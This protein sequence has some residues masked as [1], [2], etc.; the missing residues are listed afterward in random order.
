LVQLPANYLTKGRFIDSHCHLDF[1]VFDDDR[2]LILETCKALNFTAIL[3]PGVCRKDWQHLIE[4]CQKNDLLVP[5]IGLHPCFINAH[6]TGDLD[7]LE[8][9]CQSEPIVALGEM[10]LDYFILKNKADDHNSAK[11]TQIFY[12]SQQLKI[13]T[14]YQLPV[15]IHARKSHEQVIQQLKNNRSLCGIIHA[16]SGSYEQ[17]KE[18]LKLGF[19]LGFGGAFTYPNATKL[20]SLIKRLP[21]DAW[22]LE[23]DAP[24]M[25]PKKYHGQRNSPQYL[26]EIMQ[27]FLDL[28]AS[29]SENEN[30]IAQ[31]YA[32]T[33][34]VLPRLKNNFSANIQ[35]KEK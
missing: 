29:P 35:G 9:L 17:A 10:G 23:T 2:T 5:A 22:V 25:S 24:D 6:H 11:N 15:L 28:Y 16:Y 27:V 12:F 18:Y 20:R 34:D 4:L 19:K 30:I 7:L 8:Q 33:L 31:L 26:P 32:N 14:Q 3:I 21:L 13:A 1:P